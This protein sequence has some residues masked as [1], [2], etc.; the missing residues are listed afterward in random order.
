MTLVYCRQCGGQLDEAAATCPHCA[1]VQAPA[2]SPPKPVSAKKSGFKFG[3]WPDGLVVLA[4]VGGWWALI[5]HPLTPDDPAFLAADALALVWMSVLFAPPI[6]FAIQR[7][8][9]PPVCQTGMVAAMALTLAAY[10][11]AADAGISF[12]SV[13]ANFTSFAVAYFAFGYLAASCRHHE[14]LQLIAGVALVFAYLFGIIGGLWLVFA[15]GDY[16]T[17]AK[18]VRQLSDTVSCRT[19]PWGD[20]TTDSS[21]ATLHVYQ[22]LEW[23]PFL[24]R[25]L[26]NAPVHE[27]VLRT[28]EKWENTSCEAILAQWQADPTDPAPAPAEPPAEPPAEAKDE[29]PA[30]LTRKRMT[31]TGTLVYGRDFFSI[32][33]QHGKPLSFPL[34]D[35]VAERVLATCQGGDVCTL[36]GWAEVDDEGEGELIQLTSVTLVQPMLIDERSPAEKAAAQGSNSLPPMT[37]IG[38][39]SY[40]E[41]GAINLDPYNAARFSILD[42][43]DLYYKLYARCRNGDVCKVTGL[44]VHDGRGDE[45]T[46]LQ[47][48]QLLRPTLTIPETEANTGRYFA[49]LEMRGKVEAGQDD[50]G[51]GFWFHLTPV[52]LWLDKGDKIR[53]K[54]AN[55]SHLDQKARTTLTQ[56]ATKRV[57][58]TVRAAVNNAQTAFDRSVDVDIYK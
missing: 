14:G 56:L 28:G 37:S 38:R 25:E 24:E 54:I 30:P 29:A 41:Y 48:I 52:P 36:S 8:L 18:E 53:Y 2:I 19:I 42:S 23:L 22:A 49:Y 21:G 11:L 13:R 43:N 27:T 44:G 3:S 32:T 10:L 15:V 50:A 35:T 40:D 57:T 33:P 7:H 9:V 6:A 20:S 51:D 12:P 58:V 47:S 16:T 5:S 39:L 26:G 4:W 45:L 17:P 46:V 34:Y 31:V 1:A 55:A